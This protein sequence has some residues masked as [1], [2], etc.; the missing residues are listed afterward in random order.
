MRFAPAKASNE[1]A[2]V[3]GLPVNQDIEMDGLNRNICDKCVVCE[4][5]IG[6]VL[7]V[8]RMCEKTLHNDC[9]RRHEQQHH[10]DVM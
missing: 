5:Y 9:V 7:I 8:C 3:D 1:G 2:F 6:R 10:F 4:K